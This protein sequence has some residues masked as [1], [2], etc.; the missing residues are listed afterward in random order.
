MNKPSLDMRAVVVHNFIAKEYGVVHHRL[1]DETAYGRLVQ[2]GDPE[3]VTKLV[4]VMSSKKEGTLSADPLTNCKYFYI[5]GVTITIRYCIS[6][7]MDE[8]EAYYTS[9][10][11]IQALDHC[12]TEESVVKLSGDMVSFYVQKMAELK[13]AAHCSKTVYSCIS[14]IYDHMHEKISTRDLA[15]MV[16]RSPDYLEKLFKKELNTSISAYINGKKMDTARKMLLYSDFNISEIAFYL[17][18][19]SQSYFTKLFHDFY[20]LSPLKYREHAHQLPYEART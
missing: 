5:T 13:N 15:R 4:S 10:L 14:Y 20:K 18:Y 19:S 8:E 1:I 6:G 16:N 9:D 3:A 12:D 2:D 11:F 7:G 17:G